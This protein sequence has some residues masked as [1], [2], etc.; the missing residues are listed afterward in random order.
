[1][2][3]APSAEASVDAAELNPT[4][5]AQTR[6]PVGPKPPGGFELLGT[7]G[8]PNVCKHSASSF[9]HVLG[10]EPFLDA[11]FGE[12]DMETEV[13]GEVIGN[14]VRTREREGLKQSLRLRSQRLKIPKQAS[15]TP[16]RV[17]LTGTHTAV[18][19]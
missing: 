9:Q 3:N 8:Q 6:G 17:R 11:T 18:R 10:N 1:M 7:I 14:I 13:F 15:E 4:R 16:L 2:Q 19:D 12:L 5:S